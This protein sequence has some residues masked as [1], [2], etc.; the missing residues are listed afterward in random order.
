MFYIISIVLGILIGLLSKN[1][2]VQWVKSHLISYKSTYRVKFHVYFVIHRFGN[3]VNEIIKTETIEISVTARD[4][5]EAIETVNDIINNEARIEI[6][7]IDL[8]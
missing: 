4:E 1:I 3:K 8:A 5:D 2:I 7:S 6:E